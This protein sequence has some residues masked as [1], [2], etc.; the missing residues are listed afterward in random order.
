MVVTLL[1]LSCEHL[2]SSCVDMYV[3]H[4]Q[5]AKANIHMLA[6]S[7]SDEGDEMMEII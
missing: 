2:S 3:H 6:W 5:L 4:S 7:V 1:I